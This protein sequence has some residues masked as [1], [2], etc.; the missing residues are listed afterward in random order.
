MALVSISSRSPT[1]THPPST[2]VVAVLERR[3]EVLRLL[4]V[5]KLLGT[6]ASSA[7]ARYGS[8]LFG[9][10][11]ALPL[12]WVY[13]RL[14]RWRFHCARLG[15]AKRPACGRTKTFGGVKNGQLGLHRTRPG[16]TTRELLTWAL[17]IT[18]T[19][20]PQ[21]QSRQRT[22]GPRRRVARFRGAGG[23]HSLDS[24]QAWR[25]S[26]RLESHARVVAQGRGQPWR[27]AERSRQPRSVAQ[28]GGQPY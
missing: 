21:P 11:D 5:L 27:I 8:C 4:A 19:H 14:R 12:R 13:Q 7:P 3:G 17:P 9:L 15:P 24:A 16:F 26:E 6:E 25:A 20:F 28:G 1:G 22:G 18:H 23:S 10:H 2:A